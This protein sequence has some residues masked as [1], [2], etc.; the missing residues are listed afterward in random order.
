MKR[1]DFIKS[2]LGLSGGLLL[3]PQINL[4]NTNDQARFSFVHLTD[5]HVYDRRSGYEGYAKCLRSVNKL[6]DSPDFVLM[7]G[8]MVF[9]GLYNEKSDY[10]GWIDRFKALSDQLDCKW[11]PSMGNHDPFGWNPRRKTSIDDP[12]IGTKIIQEKLEWP[13]TYYSFD[14][15]GWHFTILDCIHPVDSE[16]GTIYK[17]MIDEKQ[18]AWLAN[19]LGSAGDKPKVVMLHIAV[20]YLG[21]Q[22]EGN[23]DVSAVSANMHIQ[24]NKEVREVLERH[25]VKLVL[26][27]HCHHNELVKF[28]G[29]TYLTSGAASGAWWAG[30]W[31]GAKPGYT[32]IFCT[33]NDFYTDYLTYGWEA[34]LDPKDTLEKDRQQK[35]DAYLKEQKALADR[36]R[37]NG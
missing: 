22:A 25:N 29:V 24:N 11:Y 26:Q 7:G 27:G 31:V 6:K 30:D 20:F 2:S 4:A 3:S 5:S 32:Q 17:P 13:E 19:D 1:S 35:Y 36:E 10:I 9:D 21:H 15:K 8:D 28:N 37:T 16:N 34:K 18:L 14:H 23:K 12:D 33:E